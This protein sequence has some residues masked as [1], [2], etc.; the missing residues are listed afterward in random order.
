[1]QC[2]ECMQHEAMRVRI[3]SLQ[4]TVDKYNDNQKEI[5]K[6]QHALRERAAING[7]DIKKLH[8]RMD[9]ME[10]QTEAIVRMSM[11]V[12]H[13]SQQVGEVVALLN[14]HDD[15]I[16]KLERQPG[17]KLLARWDILVVGAITSTIG[18]IL[19]GIFTY[20]LKIGGA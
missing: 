19:G 15:R 14:N 17:D 11:S 13:M 20:V 6:G 5:V 4:D 18:L 1:M 10:I 7:R 9:K 2:E 3:A 12:E 8:D 16:E